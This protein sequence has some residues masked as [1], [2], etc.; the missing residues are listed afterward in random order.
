MYAHMYMYISWYRYGKWLFEALLETP[1]RVSAPGAPQPSPCIEG[2]D[3][4]PRLLKAFLR[5]Q[6]NCQFSSSKLLI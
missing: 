6:N 3:G 5:D 4:S 1:L 2:P